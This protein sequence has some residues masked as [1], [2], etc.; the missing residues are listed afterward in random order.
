MN[1][2]IARYIVA[3]ICTTLV[4][5]GIFSVLQYGTEMRMQTANIISIL[6]AIAFA[7]VINKKFVFR[8]KSKDGLG[9]EI[10][11]FCS[12]RMISMG[13]EILGMYG[14][15]ELSSVPDLA[16]KVVLQMIV[17]G[18]NYMVSKLYIFREDKR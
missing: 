9:K 12:M 8:K 10:L 4:N 16:A 3:G 1:R 11:S 15:T 5:I 13:I 17:I 18:M 7:F 14:F 2:E 6:A